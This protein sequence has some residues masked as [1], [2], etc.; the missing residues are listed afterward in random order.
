MGHGGGRATR[1]PRHRAREGHARACG[2]RRWR[3][4]TRRAR[5]RSLR[6]GPRP[7]H[8][9]WRRRLAL[10]RAR[11]RGHLEHR[12]VRGGACRAGDRRA[13]LHLPLQSHLHRCAARVDRAHRR[14]PQ[15][16]NPGGFVLCMTQG[17]ATDLPIVRRLL[18]DGRARFIGV[19]GSEPKA[20]TMRSALMK[21]GFAEATVAGIHCPLG[22]AIGTNAPAEIAV[23][24]AA[25][26]LQVRDAAAAPG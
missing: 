9:L 19:I 17:H 20:R 23:S 14:A 2:R 22:L 21:E 1:G 18:Q 11:E 10:L 13:A 8:G 26:L 5:A 24:I 4:A 6:T 12:R 15:P 7:E 16:A 25:Q 3:A